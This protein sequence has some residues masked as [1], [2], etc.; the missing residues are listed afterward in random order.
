MEVEYVTDYEGNQVLDQNGNPV[1]ESKG[2]WSWDNLNIDL[3][4][5]SQ[6]EYDQIMELYNTIDTVSEYDTNVYDIVNEMAGSYFS[7]D[8]SLDETASLIQGK[9]QLYINEN[10]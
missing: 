5:T 4:A 2:G 6:E 10:R 8:K 3:V 7:G 9:V 1:Q